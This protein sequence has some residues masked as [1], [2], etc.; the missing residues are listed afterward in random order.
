MSSN[1]RAKDLEFLSQILDSKF[2]GPFGIKFGLDSI[3][4][5]VPGLGD[6]ITFLMGFYIIL[7]GAF[8]GLSYFTIARMLVN[9]LIDY[10]FGIIPLFGDVFDLYFRANE[11]NYKLIEEHLKNPIRTKGYSF[12]YLLLVGFLLV[13]FVTLPIVTIYY[14]LKFFIGLF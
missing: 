11:K 9:S 8:L 6:T 10:I 1:K 5:L 3:F 4:G 14:S 7:R 13:L 12:L 2:R